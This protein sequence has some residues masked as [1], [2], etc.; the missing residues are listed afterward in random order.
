MFM[1]FT[2]ELYPTPIRNTALGVCT[3]VGRL[4]AVLAPWVAVYLPHQ[5]SL[6]QW[7][8]L[9]IFGIVAIMAS[10]VSLLLPETL[11]SPLPDSFDDVERMKMSSKSMWQCVDHKQK[12]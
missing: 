7:V 2:A 6:P 5:D 10:L 12:K 3:T 4:G 8:P 1:I 9:I 11:E